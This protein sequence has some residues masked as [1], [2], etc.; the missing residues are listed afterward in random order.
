MTLKIAL[1]SS[2]TPHHRYFIN[3]MKAEGPPLELVIF[4]KKIY[5]PKFKTSPF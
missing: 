3:R 4:E 2:D 1:L 5:K